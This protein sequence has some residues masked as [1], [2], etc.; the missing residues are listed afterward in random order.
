MLMVNRSLK[1]Q[2]RS[3]L[4]FLTDAVVGA[5]GG[6]KTPSLIPIVQDVSVPT[7]QSIILP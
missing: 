3:F 4:D 1:S 7:A 6:L 5:R 2:G